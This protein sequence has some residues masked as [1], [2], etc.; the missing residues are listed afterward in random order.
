MEHNCT[1]SIMKCRTECQLPADAG[2]VRPFNGFSVDIT[3]HLRNRI[4]LLRLFCTRT[5]HKYLHLVLITW[6]RERSYHLFFWGGGES[7]Y[8]LI[9]PTPRPF[10]ETLMDIRQPYFRFA[11]G[12]IDWVA[13]F[14]LSR[15]WCDQFRVRWGHLRNGVWERC[16]T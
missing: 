3:Q 13:S 7:E 12:F 1:C 15:E 2:I 10:W 14:L 4:C 6:K 11:N 16:P 8:M 9:K 5:R